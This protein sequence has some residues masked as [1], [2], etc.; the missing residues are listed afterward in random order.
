MN[1][2]LGI[3][4]GCF[5]LLHAGHIQYINA[6][7]AQCRTLIVLINTDRSV[8]K[9]KGESRPI[10]DEQKRLYAV[11]SL[12]A[13]DQ[14]FLFDTEDAKNDLLLMMQPEFWFK[15]RPYTID[16]VLEKD[17]VHSYG[18]TVVIVD[19]Q[20]DISTTDIIEKIKNL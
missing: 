11:K 13:V 2:G 16:T 19:N 8:K 15:S 9:L 20:F 17:I 10:I 1:R 14:A 3:C 5:D 4:G 7:K 6:C 12:A 18:G